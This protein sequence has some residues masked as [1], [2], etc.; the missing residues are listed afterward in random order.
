MRRGRVCVA[1]TLRRD[2]SGRRRWSREQSRRTS[3]MSD[4]TL[5]SAD[6]IAA[7]LAAHRGPWGS[8]PGVL[9]VEDL[10]PGL[11]QAAVLRVHTADRDAGNRSQWIVKIPGGGA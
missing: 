1:S 8:G 10:S 11:G 2:P 6:E 7:V 9:E 3:M 5:P 4:R